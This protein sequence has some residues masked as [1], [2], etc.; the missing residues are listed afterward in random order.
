MREPEEFMQ[1]SIFSKFLPKAN[2]KAEYFLTLEIQDDKVKTAAC[3][4]KEGEIK[5]LSIGTADY[6]GT[7]E[8]IT[9]AVDEA[10]SQV[11]GMFP[12]EVKINQVILGLPTEFTKDGKIEETYLASIK[13]ILQK[14]SLTPLGFVEIPLAIIHFLQNQ[15]GGPQTLILVRVGKQLTVSLVRV[16]K[17]TNNINIERTE[18]IALD[19]EKAVASFTGVEILPSRILLYDGQ[20]LEKARQE[21]MNYPW[22]TK[23]SFL[24]FPKIEA[25]SS[26]ID[27]E[28]VAFAAGKETAQR[29]EIVETEKEEQPMSQSVPVAAELPPEASQET[30]KPEEAQDFG[31]VKGEDVGQHQPQNDFQTEPSEPVARTFIQPTPSFQESAPKTASKLNLPKI[32]LIPFKNFFSMTGQKLKGL[33]SKKFGLAV[34]L[35]LVL[36]LLAV[37]SVLALWYYPTAQVNIILES[38]ILQQPLEIN[39]NAKGTTINEANKEIPA[40]NLETEE[41]EVKKATTTGKKTV[42]EAA[43]GEVTIYNK[44]TNSKTFKKGTVIVSPN[45]LKFTLDD[46]VSVASASESVGSLTFGKQNIKV[47][48]ANIGPEGNLGVSQEFRFAD[49]PTSSY[50]ARNEVAFSGGTSREISVVARADQEKLLTLASTELH[51]KAKGDL[52]GKLGLGEKLIEKTLAG[53]VTQKKFDKEVDEEANEINLDLTMHFTGLGYKENDLLFLLEKSLA[54]SI[55]SGFEFKKDE[56]KLEVVEIQKKKDGNLVLKINFTSILMPQIDTNLIKKELLG[57]SFSEADKYL[58]SLGNL[59]GFEVKF[60]RQLPFFKNIFPRTGQNINIA[61]SSRK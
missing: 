12:Q 38:Q 30:E 45:N 14:L 29:I 49:F 59:A 57:K 32:S 60:G 61:T 58:R 50:S 15:E 24:H 47:T 56:V 21:L 9:I 22:L 34:S 52:S 54:P 48:A 23:A 33:L 39:L 10:L 40:L 5:V 51:E 46:E 3:E 16:G 37:G 43:K 17:I 20:E 1:P 35:A 26:N 8:E 42:G 44:T 53:T 7:W 28:S 13:N 36:L 55:P 41:K 2:A 11:E 25:A 4:L 19:F 18:N 31:F 6:S 27:I